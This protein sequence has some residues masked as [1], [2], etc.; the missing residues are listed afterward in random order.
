VASA[1]LKATRPS[2]TYRVPAEALPSEPPPEPTPDPTKATTQMVVPKRLR[3]LAL[4]TP[5]QE[6]PTTPVA[7]VAPVAPAEERLKATVRIRR[8]MALE[9]ELRNALGLFAALL[10]T[11]ALASGLVAVVFFD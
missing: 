6:L 9:A 10:A 11:S 8:A 1:T 4:P 5:A 2:A 7:P 3:E